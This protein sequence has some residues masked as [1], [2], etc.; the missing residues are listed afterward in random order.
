[1]PRASSI[2]AELVAEVTRRRREGEQWK[3]I[4]ADLRCRGL[5]AGRVTWFRALR[6]VPEHLRCG[7]TPAEAHN[8]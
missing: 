6:D 3:A 7:Q 5:P 8:A 1:M 4:S 2:T